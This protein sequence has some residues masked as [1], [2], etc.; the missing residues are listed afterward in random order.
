MLTHSN[1]LVFPERSYKITDKYGNVTTVKT[2]QKT[3]Y[4][5]KGKA[6]IWTDADIEYY[7]KLQAKIQEVKQLHEE[8]DK[9]ALNESIEE[10]IN[11]PE[12]V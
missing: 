10:L 11:E 8:M 1:E 4:N 3:I 12:P 2:R 9:Q 7:E 6:V 5:E